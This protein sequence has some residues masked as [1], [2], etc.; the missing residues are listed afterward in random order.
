METFTGIKICAILNFTKK[1]Y[2]KYRKFEIF[3]IP[4]EKNYQNLTL[5]VQNHQIQKKF[6]ILMN[7]ENVHLIFLTRE[8]IKILYFYKKIENLRIFDI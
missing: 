4:T 5:Y 2:K 3:N 8:N 6:V 7:L 1:N